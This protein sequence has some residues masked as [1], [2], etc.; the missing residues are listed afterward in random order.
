M[1]FGSVGQTI[2]RMLRL[3][4][5]SGTVSRNQW[6]LGHC[7][8][9]SRR[10]D[11]NSAFPGFVVSSVICAALAANQQTCPSGLTHISCCINNEELE[12]LPPL[13][14]PT[15]RLFKMAGGNTPFP[16]SWNKLQGKERTQSLCLPPQFITATEYIECRTGLI[17]I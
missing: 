14:W 8:D 17:R 11:P 10:N 13:R 12:L 6:P 9:S 4:Q 2:Q 5:P 16:A 7:R 15:N 3:P 1:R